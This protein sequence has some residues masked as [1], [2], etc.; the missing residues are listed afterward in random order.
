MHRL[1]NNVLLENVEIIR[2]LLVR[3]EVKHYNIYKAFQQSDVHISLSNHL[4]ANLY[5]HI[6]QL[7]DN[8]LEL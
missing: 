1:I 6:Y 4:Y 5:M 3:F 8:A 7:Y 2:W